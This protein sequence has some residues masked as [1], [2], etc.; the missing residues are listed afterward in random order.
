MRRTGRNRHRRF[1]RTFALLAAPVVLLSACTASDGPTAAR[2]H[3]IEEILDS[4]IILTPDP[5]GTFATLNVETSTPVV[6]SVVYGTSDAFGL[7]ATDD[8]MLGGAH[9]THGPRLRGL[10][11]N[12]TYSYRLQG[13][14][15]AG[16]LYQSDT[17]TFTT[18]EPIDSEVQGENVAPSATIVDVSSVFSDA[19]AAAHAIDGDL[20]TEWSSAGDGDAASLTIDLGQVTPV[21][22]ILF[23]SREM[24]DGTAIIQ[25]YTVTVDDGATFGP[26]AAGTVGEISEVSF[27]GR[28]LR[29]DATTTTGGNTGAI[30]IE[31]YR[32]PSL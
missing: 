25:K 4:E 17:L 7:I 12:T 1:L 19:F 5:S 18:P 32:A 24:T 8:D 31:I 30:E 22:G 28:I 13:S 27:D 29:F 16:T 11:P 3:P 26:L 23:R 10:T 20:T 21:V 15:A 6:C 9:V 2:V 14:D